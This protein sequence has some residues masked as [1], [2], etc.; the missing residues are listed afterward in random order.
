MAINK[1]K[2]KAE[3]LNPLTMLHTV[4]QELES[5]FEAHDLNAKEMGIADL[6]SKEKL[7]KKQIEKAC[8]LLKLDAVFAD[9]LI[10]FQ[11]DYSVKKQLC[12][13]KFSE[14]KSNYR[15]LKQVMPLLKNE[16]TSGYDILDDITDFFNVDSEEEIFAHIKQTGILY[17][18]Q[19]Q[20]DVDEINLSAW[21]RRG[22]IDFS[23]MDVAEYNEEKFQQWV[24]ARD[25]NKKLNSVAY[26]KSL[27]KILKEFGI[28]LVLLPYLSKTVYGAVKWIDGHPVVMISDRDQD[29][30]TCWFT[31]F[32]EFGHMVKHK[33]EL[34]IDGMINGKEPKGQAALRERDANKYANTYLFNG[35]EL[36][37][38][39]FELKRN[40]EFESQTVLAAK[41]NVESLFVGYWMRKA[42]YYPAQHNH[43]SI[44]FS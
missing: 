34:S 14:A 31:L 5:V 8:T 43:I 21:I 22:E 10:S 25:W 13:A 42:Q 26:F 23:N 38:H 19:N 41:Y 40:N 36:R 33:N 44:T 35:G 16:F 29:L 4:G 39:I 6:A 2:E 12:K 11:N 32:H 15:K 30:A 28:C 7:T 1:L 9:Y 37:K 18:S 24:D 20:T 3:V 17:R 27:P